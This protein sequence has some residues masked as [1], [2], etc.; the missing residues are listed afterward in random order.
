MTSTQIKALQ[1]S[2]GTTPDGFWGPKSIAA[3]QK[4]LRALMPKDNPWS[5]SDD[6]SMRAFYGAP[7]D[8]SNLVNLDVAFLNMKYE[9]KKIKTLRCHKK[10]ADSLLRV[11]KNISLGPAAWVLGE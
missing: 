6:A 9:G 1:T 3:C 10:V 5:A 4:H 7:G 11:L 8:E 2:I